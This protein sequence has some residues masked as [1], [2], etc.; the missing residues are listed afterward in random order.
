MNKIYIRVYLRRSFIGELLQKL[1]ILPLRHVV[2][3]ID[4]NAF[5]VDI[6]THNIIG[7]L[8]TANAEINN[9]R[10]M[11]ASASVISIDD[12]IALAIKEERYED[13]VK[14]QKLRNEK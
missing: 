7:I 13:V 2:L 3:N 9:N 11:P 4:L 6:T 12:Q 10:F 14:L 5:N 1:Y 8:Q